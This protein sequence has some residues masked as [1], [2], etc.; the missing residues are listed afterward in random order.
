MPVAVCIYKYIR[1]GC[2]NTVTY[3]CSQAVY[4]AVRNNQL[5][6]KSFVFERDINTVFPFIKRTSKTR[7]HSDGI[8]G[9]L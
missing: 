7:E 1:K 2:I 8:N 5:D 3:T 6:H 4:V 9:K